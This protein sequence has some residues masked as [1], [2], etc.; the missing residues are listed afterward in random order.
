VAVLTGLGF[1]TARS[2]QLP[3]THMFH[4]VAALKRTGQD[5]VARMIAAEAL[6][7]A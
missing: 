2:D 7:P 3:A 6:S 5:F 1:E 4:A